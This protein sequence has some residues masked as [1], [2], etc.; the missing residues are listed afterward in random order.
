MKQK[1][2][3]VSGVMSTVLHW[4]LAHATGISCNL[5]LLLPMLYLL[6]AL[7]TIF[8]SNLGTFTLHDDHIVRVSA[9]LEEANG[10]ANRIKQK[11]D[12]TCQ[13]WARF[14]NLLLLVAGAACTVGLTVLGLFSEWPKLW[15]PRSSKEMRVLCGRIRT[16]QQ[17]STI[18]YLWK[19]LV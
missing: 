12:L 7:W 15:I 8:G 16:L 3:L 11:R 4:R 1:W 10:N 13:L 14:C 18:M 19:V 2:K 5:L 17:T 9:V 6:C